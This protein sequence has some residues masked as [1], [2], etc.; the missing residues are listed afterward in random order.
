MFLF[1]AVNCLVRAGVSFNFQMVGTVFH[2]GT[3]LCFSQLALVASKYLIKWFE[4]ASIFCSFEASELP[5]FSN[6]SLDCDL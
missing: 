3:E 2:P 6:F 4:N 5:A 1:V